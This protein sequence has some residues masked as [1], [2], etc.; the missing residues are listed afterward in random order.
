MFI[1]FCNVV[2]NYGSFVFF[3]EILNIIEHTYDEA[4]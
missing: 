3:F 1:F 2:N 4:M